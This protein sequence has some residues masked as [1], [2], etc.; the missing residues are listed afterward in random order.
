MASA[1]GAPLQNGA[2]HTED[3]ALAEWKR[4]REK[5]RAQAQLQQESVET[6]RGS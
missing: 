6:V 1:A 5:E 3:T 2:K 4:S